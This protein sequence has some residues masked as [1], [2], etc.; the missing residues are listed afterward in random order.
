M[1]A[2]LVCGGAILAGVVVF[3]VLRFWEKVVVRPRVG[4]IDEAEERNG[5][6]RK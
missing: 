5:I 4:R 6:R 2:T 3:V 1:M